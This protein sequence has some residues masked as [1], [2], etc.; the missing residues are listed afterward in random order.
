MGDGARR[1]PGRHTGWQYNKKRD[2][3]RAG[4]LTDLMLPSGMLTALA[5]LCATSAGGSDC[6]T[7]VGAVHTNLWPLQRITLCSETF[8]SAGIK[9]ASHHAGPL[10]LATHHRP[11]FWLHFKELLVIVCDPSPHL[12]MGYGSSCIFQKKT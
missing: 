5:D 7:P 1:F 8:P 4:R 3:P 9:G 10:F 11:G 12:R 2:L 6:S